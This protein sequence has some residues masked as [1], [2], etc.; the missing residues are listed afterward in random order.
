MEIYN[1]LVKKLKRIKRGF[2]FTTYT[3]D[4]HRILKKYGDKKITKIEVCK[5]PI[6]S[7][8]ID[9][10]NIVSLGQLKKNIPFNTCHIF[11]KITIENKQFIL[12]KN[13]I[14]IIKKWKN[15][16]NTEY[17]SIELN[18]PIRLK[19][20]LHKVKSQMKY[21]YYTFDIQ[22]NN[23]QDF[24]INILNILNIDSPDIKKFIKQDLQNLY[25]NMPITEIIINFIMFFKM[26]LYIILYL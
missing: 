6:P 24:A 2:E 7:Y 11:L 13:E 3:Y 12:E 18:N 16:K 26:I 14:I 22:T 20:L 19:K 1:K 9:I 5:S 4:V 17:K 21:N 23:C 15:R 10:G 25:Y 8:I